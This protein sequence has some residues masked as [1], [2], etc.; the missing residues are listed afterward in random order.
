MQRELPASPTLT[1]SGGRVGHDAPRIRLLSG[2]CPEI[3]AAVPGQLTRTPRQ[4]GMGDR[5]L[6]QIVAVIW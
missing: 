1:R 2:A 3:L 6:A 4:G 5:A